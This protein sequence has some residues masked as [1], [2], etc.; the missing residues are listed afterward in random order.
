MRST[1][2]PT[3]AFLGICKNTSKYFNKDLSPKIIKSKD[4]K[5]LIPGS[6]PFSGLFKDPKLYEFL[7]KVLKVEPA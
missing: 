1:G 2:P 3:N 4:G 6:R 7:G 5:A